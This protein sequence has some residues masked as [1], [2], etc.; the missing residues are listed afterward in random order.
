MYIGTV[1]CPH[2]GTAQGVN[3]HVLR[4]KRVQR[5]QVSHEPLRDSSTEEK[6]Q[7]MGGASGTPYSAKAWWKWV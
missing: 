2:V 6:K 1:L 3:G 5:M 7:V 4:L